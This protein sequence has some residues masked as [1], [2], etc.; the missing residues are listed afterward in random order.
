MRKWL[1]SLAVLGFASAAA[2]AQTVPV[3]PVGACGESQM[4]FFDDGVPETSWKVFLPTGVGDAFNVDLDDMAAGMDVTGVAIN[5]WTSTGTGPLG[6]RYIALAPDNLTVSTLGN[7]PSTVPYS[8]RSTTTGTITGNPGFGAGYCPGLVGFDVPDFTVPA[9]G[10]LH[11]VTTFLTGDSGTWLCSDQS[12]PY[13]GRSFFTSSGYLSAATPMTANL[14]IRVIA[15]MLNPCPG[16][17][18][19]S[20]YLTVNNGVNGVE[21]TQ[22]GAVTVSLWS[23]C[24]TTP[25]QLPVI[26][27]QGVFIPPSSTF[28]PVPSTILVT[29]FDYD[30]LTG[31]GKVANGDIFHGAFCANLSDPSAG[32]VPTGATFEVGA[33]YLDNCTLKK[34]GKPKL[35]ITNLVDVIVTA[36]LKKCN[37]CVCFGQQ[38]D[39]FQ[40]F[41]IWKVQNPA[42]SKDYFNV[43]QGAFIDP[44]TS[45]TCGPY[46]LLT[47]VEAASWD[48]CGTGP[49][50]G[51]VG[52]YPANTTLDPSGGT[53]NV[54]T[55]VAIAST[56]SMSP[57]SADY[58]Y[59]ATLYSFSTAATVSTT[60][61]LH[62]AT[63]WLTGDTCVWI[64]SDTD[65]VDDDTTSTGPICST[66]PSST[67]FFTAD[68]YVTNAQ[69][70]CNANWMQKI[71][72]L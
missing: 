38:D 51:E 23:C 18:F 59:P 22:A 50:W 58:S 11:A 7:T 35:R 25:V 57:G 32:C 65:G 1:A 66:I 37:P 67:S 5:T 20:A 36:D 53:P 6:I 48:F 28:F 27:L 4:L 21:V 34:N 39:G 46:G 44:T 9:S 8:I 3:P 62:S 72:Y 54:G 43:C 14:Q 29:G 19:D 56:L 61:A 71:N 16:P 12:C 70:Y 42:G 31:A 13:A 69:G 64:G 17:G 33:F 30:F 49:S 47:G 40:D 68:G 55:P 15:S 24:V 63:K 52:V 41:F 45:G 26:Y 10:G 2:T 60:V